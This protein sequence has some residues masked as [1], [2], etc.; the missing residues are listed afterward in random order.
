MTKLIGISGCTNGGKTTLSKNLLNEYPNSIH[1]SQDEFYLE[2]NNQNYEFI[3]EANSFNFDV[4][5]AIDMNQFHKKLSKLVYNGKYD[6]IFIDGILLYEDDK[7]VKMLD[8]KY[9]LDLDKEEAAKRRKNRHYIMKETENYFEICAWKQF[10]I[11][12]QKCIQNIKNIIFLN[13]SQSRE[14]IF[15]F[16]LSDLP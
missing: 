9:F 2:R 6:Y 13:G 8:R 16:V 7:L 11:Y 3:E 1:L 12:K 4:I 15:K 14:E 5:T 10:L